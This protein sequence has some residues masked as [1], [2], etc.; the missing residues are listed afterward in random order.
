MS[1]ENYISLRG[2][3]RKG[4]QFRENENGD[5]VLGL[6]PLTTVRRDLRD[7]NGTINPKFDQPVICTSDNN[8]LRW[9]KSLK[10]HDLVEVKGTFMTQHSKKRSVCPHCGEEQIIDCPIQTIN[11]SFVGVLKDTIK[12]DAEGTKYLMDC[13]EVSNI[14]KIIGTVC[15]PTDDI[16]FGETDRGDMYARYQL[17]VNRKLFVKGSVDE[18]DHTDYPIVY[19][20]GN[21]A[22]DDISVLRQGSEVYLDGFIHTMVYSYDVECPSCGEVHQEKRQRMN[23]T[24]YSME[25]LRDFNDDVL[26]STHVSIGGVTV[27]D[28]DEEESKK[29]RQEE[30]KN[31]RDRQEMA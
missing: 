1:R 3:L 18:E 20:Y 16:V 23:L 11:P 12:S 13:A 27:K 14:A 30:L 15:T 31:V 28:L 24:P 29:K 21:V 6:M 25:Y 9:M 10:T 2:Q 8:I 26:E 19:S 17:A 22:S 5:V 7:E 4:I